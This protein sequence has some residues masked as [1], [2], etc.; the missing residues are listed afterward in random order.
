M[1]KK[2]F[3]SFW[4]G[5]FS[6][7]LIDL[8]LAM[9]AEATNFSCRASPLRVDALGITIFEPVVANGRDFPCLTAS[10]TAVSAFLPVLPLPLLPTPSISATVLSAHTVDKPAATDLPDT[11]AAK[12]ASANI[13]GLVTTKLV[14]ASARVVHNTS[15]TACRLSGASSVAGAVVLGIP[16]TVGSAPLDVPIPLIGVLHFNKQITSTSGQFKTL[17]QRAVWLEVTN[18]LVLPIVADVIV[19]EA[20]VDIKGNPCST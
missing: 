20:I 16:V 8:V 19:G 7:V 18:V 10:D 9:P 14:T 11:A 6:L 5:A 3:L 15:D 12:L 2:S 13:L 4:I 17:V 1:N